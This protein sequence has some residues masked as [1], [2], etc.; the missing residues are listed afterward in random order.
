MYSSCVVGESRLSIYPSILFTS[1]TACLSSIQISNIITY[2]TE[3]TRR[4][5][6]TPDALRA[7]A[8]T[9]L[10]ALE[11]AETIGDFHN[12]G[13]HLRFVTVAAINVS[14]AVVLHAVGTAH[15]SQPPNNRGA[16]NRVS[17][18]KKEMDVTTTSSVIGPGM[19]N[20]D[21]AK[22]DT[23]TTSTVA[24]S[25]PMQENSAVE[26]SK[27]QREENSE[28]TSDKKDASKTTENSPVPESPAIQP[29]LN[30]HKNHM[31]PK[32]IQ[33][34]LKYP[35]PFSW[36]FAECAFSSILSPYSHL[37][38][39]MGYSVLVQVKSLSSDSLTF[40]KR[41]L[42]PISVYSRLYAVNSNFLVPRML[43]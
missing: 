22:S 5:V 39:Y 32:S 35:L 25:P 34:L 23:S 15:S 38:P 36:Y 29:A 42:V 31:L 11:E 41:M 12:P 28:V 27:E 4:S 16:I 21:V 1:Y 3:R 17:Q 7:F 43:P 19:N 18:I 37:A 8:P 2:V 24:D 10:L 33:N 30:D 13:A 20:Q 6:N 40:L 9:L 26:D 14:R